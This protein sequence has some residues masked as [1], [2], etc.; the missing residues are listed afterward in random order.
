MSHIVTWFELPV[1]DMPRAKTFYSA[2]MDSHFTDENMDGMK[3]SV[4]NFDDDAVSGML[5]EAEHYEPS[6]TGA[7]VYLNGGAD[8]DTPLQR[9]P[10]SGGEI[11]MQKTAISDGSKGHFALFLDSE[12]N[13]VGLY[14]PPQ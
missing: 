5:V 7:V 4:F 6:T 2:V 13:R 1:T 14:S 10:S 3:M 9:V 12:G 8:L 11:L